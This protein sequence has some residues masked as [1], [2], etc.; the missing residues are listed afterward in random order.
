[1]SEPAFTLAVDDD[2][3]RTLR[4]EREAREQ[5][6]REQIVV[7]MPYRPTSA[8]ALPSPPRPRPSRTS[9]CHSRDWWGSFSRLP[10]R[11]SRAAPPDKL[12]LVVGPGPADLLSAALEAQGLELSCHSNARA[13]AQRAKP[14]LRKRRTR[15]RDGVGGNVADAARLSADIAASLWHQFCPAR[16]LSARGSP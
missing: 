1:M 6:A 5:Q 16:P 13:A 15:S 7:S 14:I 2:L 11:Y 8:A 12:A 4:R 9:M 10:G 3:P